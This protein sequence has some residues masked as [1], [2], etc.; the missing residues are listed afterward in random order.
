MCLPLFAAGSLPAQNYYLATQQARRDSAMNDAEQQRIQKEANGGSQAGVAAVP[1]PVTPVDPALQATLKNISS[2]QLDFAQVIAAGDKADSSQKVALLN[3]L[4]QAAQ[5]TKAS[6][7]SVKRLADDLM[8]AL[9]GG[10]I[11]LVAAQQTKLARDIHALFNSSH[12]SSA[13]QQ[14]LLDDAQKT[15]TNAGAALADGVNV[16]TDLKAIVGETK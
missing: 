6:A 8:T 10:K 3:D 7:D 15:L 5:G 4:T 1:G 2:L 11:K 16:T 14:T 9:G 12:L 13:V